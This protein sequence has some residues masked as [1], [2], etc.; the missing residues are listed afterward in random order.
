MSSQITSPLPSVSPLLCDG[1]VGVNLLL[2]GF[3]SP[4]FPVLVLPPH[5]VSVSVSGVSAVSL[6]AACGDY[7]LL[8]GVLTQTQCFY[9]P[10]LGY[11]TDFLCTQ[12]LSSITTFEST[13]F[14]CQSFMQTSKIESVVLTS[15]CASTWV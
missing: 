7:L 12:P 9:K 11:W 4:V 10:L 15:Q 1:L 13:C 5:C 6:W 2:V 3:P 14:E 8:R